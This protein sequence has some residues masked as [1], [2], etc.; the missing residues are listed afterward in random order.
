MPFGVVLVLSALSPAMPHSITP[1]VK[2]WVLAWVADRGCRPCACV[3]A[4]RLP[5][6][7]WWHTATP[8]LLLPIVQLL[9][10][11]DGFAA[12]GFTPLLFLPILWFA[13]YGPLRDVVIGLLGAAIVFLWPILVDRRAAIPGVHA[14]RVVAVPDRLVGDGARAQRPRALVACCDRSNWR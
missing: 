10:A 6:G 7:H 4:T 12:S 13:L 9:R 14:A 3:V 5:N 1:I 8:L 2:W 11:A